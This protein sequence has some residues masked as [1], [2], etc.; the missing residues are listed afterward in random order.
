[1]KKFLFALVLSVFAVP[2]FAAGAQSDDVS[3]TLPTQR[4]DGTPLPVNEIDRIE[5][6]VE[7]DGVVLGVEAFPA[8]ITSYTYTR[9][10]PPNYTMCYRARTVDT[11][12]LVSDWTAQVCKTVK[13]KPNPPSNL[14][15]Q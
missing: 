6:E 10:L 7:K 1:M 3:W 2:A 5:I 14:R 12:S 11:E 4:V 13:G 15:V 9:D 8:S